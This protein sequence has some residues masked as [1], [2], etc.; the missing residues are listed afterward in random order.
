M[1]SQAEKEGYERCECGAHFGRYGRYAG[2]C[3]RCG[4]K[5]TETDGRDVPVLPGQLRMESHSQLEMELR[6]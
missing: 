3:W 5:I 4:R 1:K 6:V 2:Y